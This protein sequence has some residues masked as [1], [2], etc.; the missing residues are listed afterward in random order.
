MEHRDLLKDQI[1]Q[2][3]KA[4]AKV[5]SDFLSIKAGGN[6]VLA[7][8]FT[9]ERL[10]SQLDLDVYKI[11][12]LEDDSLRTY[13]LKRTDSEDNIERLSNLFIEFAHIHEMSDKKKARNY[14]NKSLD[15]MAIADQVSN[16]YSLERK[17]MRDS[18]EVDIKR[19]SA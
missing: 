18:I 1:E 8:E 10:N 11:L 9:A 2:F 7:T 6:T 17:S 12:E 13:L 16:S 15:L 3:G 14:L 5:L 19:L 4:L